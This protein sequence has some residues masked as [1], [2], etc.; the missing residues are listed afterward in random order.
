MIKSFV[1]NVAIHHLL[2]GEQWLDM[3]CT[4]NLPH[5]LIQ[6]ANAKPDDMVAALNF[7]SYLLGIH[8]AGW[9]QLLQLRQGHSAETYFGAQCHNSTLLIE[10][11]I[12]KMRTASTKKHRNL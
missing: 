3:V 8:G 1:R 6:L 11:M 9:S 12:I 7:F 4:S 5:K 2:N 10:N